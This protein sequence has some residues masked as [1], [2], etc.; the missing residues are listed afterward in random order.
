[1]TPESQAVLVGVTG[2]GENTDA[3]RFAIAQAGATGRPLRLV[4][5]AQ[6]L[7]PP[8]PPSVLVT[9]DVL[10]EVG[11]KAMHGVREELDELM[12]EAGTSVPVRSRVTSGDPGRVLADLSAEA[13]VVVLQHRNLSRT[14]RLFTGST[15]SATS[16]HAHCPVVSV[17]AGTSGRSGG[18][19]CVV[20]GVTEDGGPREAAEVAFEEADRRGVAVRLVHAWHL[21][22]AYDDVLAA[23]K[24]WQSTVEESVRAAADE[25]KAKHPAVPTEVVVEHEWPVE[26]LVEASRGADLLVLGRHARRHPGP[27]RLGSMGRAVLAYADCPV[28]IVPL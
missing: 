13:S 26:S 9:P 7:L 5:V 19:G 23:D 27:A 3:L 8:V 1:M 20:V 11:K 6:G 25:L 18:R 16:T 22:P 17:S 24:G 15:V 4:H 10:I 28:M 2:R 14:H 12:R 21:A